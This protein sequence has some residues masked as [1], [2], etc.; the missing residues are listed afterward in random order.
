[1]KWVILQYINCIEQKKL[2][3]KSNTLNEKS[4]WFLSLKVKVAEIDEAPT[5]DDI[6]LVNTSH[7]V[8]EKEKALFWGVCL[9][10]IGSLLSKISYN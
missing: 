5:W 9:I 8:V 10:I 7:W 1:M 3:F 4:K 6:K 2:S